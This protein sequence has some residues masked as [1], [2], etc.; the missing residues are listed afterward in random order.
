M[1]SIVFHCLT[2]FF[3]SSLVVEV[4]SQICQEVSQYGRCSSN[5][6]CG[7]LH[8]EGAS[9]IGIC[10]FQWVTCSDLVPCEETNNYC[11]QSDHICVHHPRCHERPLCFPVSMMDAKLCP[12]MNV[13]NT[14][15][16][17]AMPT[18]TQKPAFVPLRASTIEIL[19][20]AQWKQ[21]G[22]TLTEQYLLVNGTNNTNGIF[23]P[24]GVFVDD[25]Q[26][27]Y[28]TD[29]NNGQVMKFV[30]GA[31]SGQI[32]AGGNGKGIGAHQLNGPSDVIVDKET[33]SLIICDNSNKR[34]VRWPR[35]NGIRGE[36]IIS[37]VS[38]HGLTMDE[39][40]SLYVVGYDTAEVRLYRKGES[41]GSI[42]AGGNGRGNRLDQLDWPQYIFVDRDRSIYV[43][44][45]Y[46]HRVTK[47]VE[48]AKQ[49]IVVAGG[50]GQGNSLKQ[51][52]GPEGV[53]V[54]QSGGVYVAD[55]FNGRV[56][57]WAKGA[58]QG[59]IIAGGNGQGISSNQVSHPYGIAFDRYGNLY[60][61]DQ[62]NHR[63]QKF[64]IA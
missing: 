44:E 56:V 20:N 52:A 32:V 47:W 17:T 3:L 60:V 55:G 36:T 28:V 5:S 11:G 41:Q 34:V 46:N 29:P 22:I 7:C 43:S 48:G 12:P 57:R 31:T 1:V 37:N 30:L 54:D 8:M 62:W 42:V 59:T 24:M 13:A 16:S 64:S 61:V 21:N 27:V 25:E 35:V 26:T 63:V 9:N 53:L 2:F 15:S 40:G 51:F 4:N 50:N 10:G 45:W 49:G 18:T 39:S 19:P 58:T 38:C 23:A 6:A 33:N 14:T